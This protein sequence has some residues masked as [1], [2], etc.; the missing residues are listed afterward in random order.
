MSGSAC[1]AKT[2]LGLPEVVL[3]CL[4]WCL[5]NEDGAPLDIGY[6]SSCF[7]RT[8]RAAVESLESKHTCYIDAESVKRRRGYTEGL[9]DVQRLAPDMR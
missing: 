6:R 8:V 5:A 1:A 3:G 4:A 2:N 9:V 7:L